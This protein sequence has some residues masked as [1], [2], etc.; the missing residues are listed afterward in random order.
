MKCVIKNKA[1][2]HYL[3]QAHYNG[4]QYCDKIGYA[5]IYISE[6]TAETVMEGLEN[7]IESDFDKSHHEVIGVVVEIREITELD[8]YQGGN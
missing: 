7:S 8:T 5:Q 2:G 4:Y 1:T 6:S 3:R